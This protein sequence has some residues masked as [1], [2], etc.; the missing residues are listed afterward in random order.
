MNDDTPRETENT[1]TAQAA[2]G[3][4]S[5]GAPQIPVS[6]VDTATCESC[7]ATI[8]V[9]GIEPFSRVACPSCGAERE[10]PGKFAHFVLLKHLGTGGMGTTFLAEEEQ[11]GRRVAVKVIRNRIEAGSAEY[12]AFKNEAQSA[13][14]LN[15]PHV[16]Q[17][18]SFGEEGGCPYLE[19]ELV[20]GGDL[21]QF[22][23]KGATLDPAFVMRVGLEIA[24]GLKAAEEV[25]LFHGDVK[26]DNILFDENMAAKL[27]DFGIASR[28]SQGAAGELWGTP[29]YI[30]PEKVQKKTNSARSDIYSLGATLYHA[31]AGKPPYDGEDAVAVIKAR[32]AGPPPAIETLRPDVEPEVSRILS[33]MMYNDLFMRYPN[34]TSL[35][36]DLKKYLSGVS[37]LRKQGPR[38][39]A[40]RAAAATGSFKA[41]ADVQAPGAGGK[42]KFVIQKGQLEAA[43]AMKEMEAAAG[44]GGDG[45]KKKVIRLGGASSGPNEPVIT[46]ENGDSAGDGE[47]GG[48]KRGFGCSLKAVL[49][50]VTGVVVL[51][52][53]GVVVAI[54]MFVAK[55]REARAAEA[56]TRERIAEVES[57][58]FKAADEIEP[59]LAAARARD[60]A[61]VKEFKPLDDLAKK[62]FDIPF[63]VPDLEPAGESA[64]APAP[65]EPQAAPAAGAAASPAADGAEAPAADGAEAPAPADAGADALAALAGASAGDLA[66]LAG[67]AG[68]D[69]AGLAGAA[70]P[71]LAS[72]EQKVLVHARDVRAALRECEK[73]AA[74]EPPAFESTRDN[75]PLEAL[76][77][78]LSVREKAWDVR[79]NQIARMRAI[80]GRMDVSTRE[81][82]RGVAK[83]V[84]E[85][86]RYVRER[87]RREAEA[88]AAEAE[89]QKELR[90]QE[91]AAEAAAR[92]AEEAARVREVAESRRELLDR[93]E[94]TVFA[95][96]M[97][98][99]E[100]E[101]ATPEGKE[102]LKWTVERAERL[103]A[104]QKF[105]LDDVKRH[106]EVPRGFRGK[107]LQGLSADG[108]SLRVNLMPD[109]QIDKM[110]VADWVVLARALLEKRG[111]DRGAL[112]PSEHGDMLFNTA[113]F[114]YLHGNGDIGAATLAKNLAQRA[115]ELRAALRNDAERL[116]PIL[117]EDEEAGEAAAPSEGAAA[118][119]F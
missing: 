23:V 119:E 32:F 37:D 102:E 87:E 38:T 80:L 48:R 97:K 3:Q 20:P 61:M 34:Y 68:G 107:T 35:I 7:G 114:A 115:L 63:P 25:G 2:P 49:I 91:E 10:I 18:Y 86:Q 58:Y 82:K 21:A 43:E 108:K 16:A 83:V 65:A 59:V 47:D 33:R 5:P 111:H 104:L 105:L 46:P 14:R 106:G 1:D 30:A 103:A 54:A 45:G 60:A 85:G 11:L 94:Y 57:G 52:I 12:E 6:P 66:A 36:G 101:L 76:E 24:E 73:I 99:M 69:I 88:A 117:V 17:V 19:M 100:Q 71:L 28:A 92:G 15:H 8:D 53:A 116:L 67:M 22:I 9:R 51:A 93:F 4:P 70:A 75:M 96:R 81:M 26:P 118:L 31:I 74:E 78:A 95:D 113:I 109:F 62:A 112:S 29:F 27:V 39:A 44:G 13:A 89:R 90:K 77:Q 42:K 56:S 79:T 50:A 98:R 72:V 84:Q 110:T 40:A 64:P 55:N 41:P